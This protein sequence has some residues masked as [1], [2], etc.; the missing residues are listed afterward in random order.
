MFAGN[1]GR[2]FRNR[3]GPR[4]GIRTRAWRSRR[5][6]S[7]VVATILLLALT[8]VLFA[9][10]F[11]FV[12][13]FP[14]PPAQNSNQFQ[15]QII[16][17]QNGSS[18][19]QPVYEAQAIN[20]L[21]LAG[22][23]VLPGALVY[24]ASSVHPT[25]PEFAAPYTMTQGG[26]PAGHVW[27]LG[28]T[29]VLNTNFTKV[30]G[31]AA[32]HP[33]L[34][35]NLTIYIVQGS[36]LLFSAV[37]PGTFLNLAPTFLSVGTNLP[38]PALGEAFT[39][40]ALI[41]GVTSA[42]TAVTISVAGLPLVTQPAATQR[43]W[44]IGGVWTYNETAGNTTASGTYYAFI[45]A[46]STAGKTGTSAVPVFITA[47]STLI[48]NAFTVGTV[49]IGGA[50]CTAA[51]TPQAACQ[52]SGDYYATATISLSYV[53]FGSILF[54]VYTTASR[55]PYATTGH[56]AFAVALTATPTTAAATWIGAATGPLL[57]SSSGFTT[58]AGG[59]TTLSPLTT[60][61]KISIDLGTVAPGVNTLSF[62]VLGIGPYSSSTAP[63]TVP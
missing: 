7:D 11:A 19:G 1:S 24:L 4:G 30:C 41:Q 45:T 31:G 48:A 55:V 61:Y 57:M 62:V 47:Y 9:S 20:I 29:W 25:G 16:S 51:A 27:N 14:S 8:V 22:P 60:L 50:T 44:N 38:T 13:S 26:I 43:M 35:D 49:S 21:H 33:I 18:M 56:A 5:A 63:V 54:E 34:P 23:S 28:Q 39:I 59:F 12:S 42:S 52:A 58:Y 36:L 32:C 17:A 3:K 37:I 15:A 46:T 10:I 40:T 53:T 2:H 6:V